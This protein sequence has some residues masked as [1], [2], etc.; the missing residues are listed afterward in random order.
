MEVNSK[1]FVTKEE[2]KSMIENTG[3][4][5]MLAQLNDPLVLDAELDGIEEYLNNKKSNIH[6]NFNKS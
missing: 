3:I 1:L 6:I 2:R 4:A 5:Y